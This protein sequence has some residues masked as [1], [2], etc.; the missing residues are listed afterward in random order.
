MLINTQGVVTPIGTIERL[1]V[2][3]QG[4][5]PPLILMLQIWKFFMVIL[6]AQVT[7]I[8]SMNLL[9][10]ITDFI[11]MSKVWFLSIEFYGVW[12]EESAGSRDY[13]LM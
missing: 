6:E 7:Q 1:Y 12:Q 3:S 11:K 9:R 13:T 2:T 4:A 8:Y 5:W 10:L